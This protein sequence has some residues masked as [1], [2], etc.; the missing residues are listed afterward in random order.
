ME[1]PCE[2]WS[3]PESY[4]GRPAGRYREYASGDLISTP[5]EA[6]SQKLLVESLQKQQRLFVLPFIQI[7]FT[8]LVQNSIYIYAVFINC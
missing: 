4:D 8:D 2:I 3:E 1:R 5:S 6:F 7:T